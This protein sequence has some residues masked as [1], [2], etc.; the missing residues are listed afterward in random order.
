MSRQG[1]YVTLPG[2]SANWGAGLSSSLAD[3]SKTFINQANNEKERERLNKAAEES[4]RRYEADKAYRLDRDSILDTRAAEQREFE[5]KKYSDLLERQKEADRIA[6]AERKRL[7]AE[8][9]ALKTYLSNYSQ[10]SAVDAALASDPR[11]KTALDEQFA[12][13]LEE[14]KDLLARNAIIDATIA[15]QGGMGS[16]F[17]VNLGLVDSLVPENPYAAIEKARAVNP[18][19]AMVKAF[20]DSV[21]RFKQEQSGYLLSNLP[22]YQEQENARI[23][24]EMGIAGVNPSLIAGISKDL[25][26]VYRSIDDV[27]AEAEAQYKAQVTAAK[28]KADSIYKALSLSNKGGTSGGS[29]TYIKAKDISDLDAEKIIKEKFDANDIPFI[30]TDNTDFLNWFKAAKE[31]GI[32]DAVAMRALED[33]VDSSI[34]G[35]SEK[36][37]LEDYLADAKALNLANEAKKQGRS[38]EEI[39]K[40]IT[41]EVVSYSNPITANRNA[42]IRGALNVNSPDTANPRSLPLVPF[43]GADIASTSASNSVE[44]TNP[45]VVSREVIEG[46]DNL[47]RDPNTGR[48]MRPISGLWNSS[49]INPDARAGIDREL[50]FNARNAELKAIDEQ[51]RIERALA[52]AN[53]PSNG[54][55]I[56]IY[57]NV[58]I[59]GTL[60]EGLQSITP[61]TPRNFSAGDLNLNPQEERTMVFLSNRSTEFLEDM[62]K[63]PNLTA[64]ERKLIP[65][66]LQNRR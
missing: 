58:D 50:R 31:A 11:L 57:E 34:L 6:E 54:E 35:R 64:A 26:G 65:I 12:T 28:N 37:S 9:T 52:E 19:S 7:E 8:R 48:L 3:L 62:I 49:S 42:F 14:N 38:Y 47:R 51:R 36:G 32:P 43:A 39:I 23:R 17:G 1:N 5:Q 60:R 46:P 25:S 56:D 4:K 66:I 59:P 30:D 27:T 21:A 16:E 2:A 40:L 33:K 18:D 24:R 53:R 63:R 20:D 22:I 15:Q 45:A 44:A 10:Q 29:G 55:R 41:P 61:F 13:S